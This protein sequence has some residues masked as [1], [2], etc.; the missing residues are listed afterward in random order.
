MLFLNVHL[1][2]TQAFKMCATRAVLRAQSCSRASVAAAEGQLCV[3]PAQQLLP[4]FWGAVTQRRA[5]ATGFCRLGQRRGYQGAAQACM[6]PED[7]VG[8]WSPGELF[9]HTLRQHQSAALK[10][11]HRCLVLPCFYEAHDLRLYNR[12]VT[13]R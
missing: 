8:I 13:D 4:G 9:M 3:A 6:G 2:S 12:R 11:F 1:H 7:A 5:C 10:E